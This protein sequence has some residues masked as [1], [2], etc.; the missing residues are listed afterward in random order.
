MTCWSNQNITG[1]SK[2]LNTNLDT[3]PNCSDC[4]VTWSCAPPT[5]LSHLHTSSYSTPH[6]TQH[7]TPTPHTTPHT[8]TTWN[9]THQHHMQ[10]NTQH[11]TPTPHATQ[12]TTPHTKRGCYHH[13]TQLC[14]V[15]KESTT[16]HVSTLWGHHQAATAYWDCRYVNATSPDGILCGLHMHV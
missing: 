8:N 7:H 1:P 2:V 16:L 5:Q 14:T 12:Y 11:H 6:A 13:Q 9:T 3:E 15:L 10:H 4:S